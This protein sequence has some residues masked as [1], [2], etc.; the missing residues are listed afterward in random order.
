MKSYFDLLD[1][2]TWAEVKKAA[3][4]L[5]EIPFDAAQA[6]VWALGN[7]MREVPC[8]T[9]L[10]GRKYWEGSLKAILLLDAL[11]MEPV[12]LGKALRLM[13]LTLWR[14]GDGYHAAWSAEQYEILEKNLRIGGKNVP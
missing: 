12:H 7:F 14:E 5:T 9:D 13:G 8:H 2:D 6:A 10:N 3:P 4:K 11:N 1:V